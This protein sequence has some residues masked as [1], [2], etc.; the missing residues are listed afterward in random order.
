MSDSAEKLKQYIFDTILDLSRPDMI[1]LF[2]DICAFDGWETEL[3]VGD[4][5]IA[6]DI[7]AIQRFPIHQSI[8]V[9]IYDKDL[10][11]SQL[12]QDFELFCTAE[13]TAMVALVRHPPADE[14]VA[15]AE[16]NNVTFI[17]PTDI[18]TKLLQLPVPELLSNYIDEKEIKSKFDKYQSDMVKKGVESEIGSGLE[19]TPSVGTDNGLTAGI[20]GVAYD[21]DVTTILSPHLNNKNATATVVLWEVINNMN[22]TIDRSY[23]TGYV[24]DDGMGA[25]LL[26]LRLSDTWTDDQWKVAG[27]GAD[28]IPETPPGTRTRWIDT[29]NI[30]NKNELDAALISYSRPGGGVLLR[31]PISDTQVISEE[32]LPF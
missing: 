18:T 17:D 20:L 8:S 16:N 22:K 26:N 4:P 28:D 7:F 29:L 31:L 5:D 6:G 23:E 1:S 2:M 27:E 19:F 3:G 15:F 14:V 13:A 32:S 30:P 9:F 21:V 12:E 10:T 11:Q 25:D 24:R